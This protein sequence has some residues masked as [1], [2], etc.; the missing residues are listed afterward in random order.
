M[1]CGKSKK[2][3]APYSPWHNRLLA[4]NFLNGLT[5]EEQNIILEVD[6]FL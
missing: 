2:K 1:E 3:I 4:A 6:L 5:T